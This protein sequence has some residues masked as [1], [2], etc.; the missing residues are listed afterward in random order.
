MLVT[1]ETEGELL[2][3]QGMSA[4]LLEDLGKAVS[5][6]EATNEKRVPAGGTMSAPGPT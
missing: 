1:A 3:S 4:T 2:V 6:F 5:E